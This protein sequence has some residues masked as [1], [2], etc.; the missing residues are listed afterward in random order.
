MSQR[1][2]AGFNWPKAPLWEPFFWLASQPV[3]VS[4]ETSK[5]VFRELHESPASLY[6]SVAG[7]PAIGVG[8]PATG[9]HASIDFRHW[10]L[11]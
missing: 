4:P 3:G 2:C 9:Q 5:R 6:V 1:E 11:T 8:H 10:P 7:L